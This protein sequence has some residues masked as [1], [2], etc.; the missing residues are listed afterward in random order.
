ML[1]ELFTVIVLHV[2]IPILGIELIH[3]GFKC[4]VRKTYVHKAFNIAYLDID[5]YNRYHFRRS[6][7]LREL[8]IRLDSFQKRIDVGNVL[9]RFPEKLY[10][11]RYDLIY[12]RSF[13]L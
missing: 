1:A 11:Y 12:D 10:T 6:D 9:P 5:S 13:D 2:S 7:Y 4:K 3:Y 8:R